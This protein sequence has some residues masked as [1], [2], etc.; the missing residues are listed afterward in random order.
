M[1]QFLRRLTNVLGYNIMDSNHSVLINLVSEINMFNEQISD[2][3]FC[4]QKATTMI[5]EVY[6]DIRDMYEE[7]KKHS[8]DQDIA[9]LDGLVE[10]LIKSMETCRSATAQ[11]SDA[12]QQDTVH[13]KLTSQ[14][15]RFQSLISAFNSSPSCTLSG[16]LQVH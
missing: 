4:S 13:N 5:N 8:P 10:N 1:Y 7:L 14:S 2:L 9:Q 12:Y 3:D 11:A 6:K 15:L 16:F